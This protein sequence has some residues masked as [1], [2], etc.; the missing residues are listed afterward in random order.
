MKAYTITPVG[1]VHKI[2][3]EESAIEVFEEHSAGLLRIEACEKLQI[4]FWMH[5][6]SEDELKMMQAHPMKDYDK[7]KRGVFALRSPMRPNPMGITVV[8]FVK[9]DGNRLHVKG[10]DALDGSPVIDIKCAKC[11]SS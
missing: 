3:A 4:L 10:L 8:D 11:K 5:K 6:L 7:P 1:I 9:K 2:S